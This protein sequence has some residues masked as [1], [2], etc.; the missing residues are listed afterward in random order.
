MEIQGEPRTYGINQSKFY[1]ATPARYIGFGRV[2][3]NI[4]NF[5][6]PGQQPAIIAHNHGDGLY[7]C[8]MPIQSLEFLS[9]D[10]AL[11]FVPKLQT[12]A[13]SILT[14]GRAP[15]QLHCEIEDVLRL[16]FH[17]DVPHGTAPEKWTC[18]QLSKP[19]QSLTSCAATMPSRTHSTC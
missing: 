14:P 17:D 10:E 18:F 2:L 1:A 8:P 12:V 11:A 5:R 4:A 16:Y 9:V 15:A 3:Q 13:I 7:I 6:D 19:K